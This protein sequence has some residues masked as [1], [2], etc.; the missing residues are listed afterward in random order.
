M[1][2]CQ[3]QK[4]WKI[5]WWIRNVKS[6]NRVI[7]R[8]TPKIVIYTDGSLQFYGAKLQD[9]KIGSR[10]ILTECLLHIYAL[11][12]LAIFYALKA[13]QSNKHVKVLCDN[14]TPV[15]SIND[16]SGLKSQQCNKISTRYLELVY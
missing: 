15:N 4:A 8:G 14:T 11:E 12:L 3:Y 6:Q 9:I 5:S 13:F 1:Q 2:L 10:L 7:G 16:M